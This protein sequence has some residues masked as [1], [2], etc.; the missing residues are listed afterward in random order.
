MLV[1]TELATRMHSS[2]MRT[3]LLSGHLGGW[4]VCPGGSVHHPRTQRQTSVNGTA[5]TPC[6]IAF[7]DTHPRIT[8]MCKKITL[9]QTSFAGSNNRDLMK[10]ISRLTRDTYDVDDPGERRLRH[11]IELRQNIGD[12]SMGAWLPR[13]VMRT[14][15]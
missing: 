14:I 8:D 1:V 10:I 7:W 9:P 5:H 11:L 12:L 3:A 6:P 2:R 4:D 15:H 13:S